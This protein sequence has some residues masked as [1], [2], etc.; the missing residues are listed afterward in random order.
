MTTAREFF[1]A[2]RTVPATGDASLSLILRVV[3]TYSARALQEQ[4]TVR[5][6]SLLFTLDCASVNG[7]EYWGTE[8][9]KLK[10]QNEYFFTLFMCGPLP[11]IRLS[12]KLG[13]YAS[14]RMRN[15]A[16]GSLLVSVCVCVCVKSKSTRP[17]KIKQYQTLQCT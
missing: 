6:H 11:E 17:M 15:Q 7:V 12:L 9:S 14:V 1:A 8:S 3:I 2:T 4:L 16:Y 13:N 5:I 10:T